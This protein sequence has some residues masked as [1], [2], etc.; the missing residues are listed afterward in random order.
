MIYMKHDAEF[1]MDKSA[2]SVVQLNDA[3]DELS[4]WLTRTPL[5]RLHAIELIRQTL[6]GYSYPAPRLQ[7]VLTVAQLEHLPR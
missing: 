7:R 3:D 2:F 5:E 1:K 6:Y 4:Y